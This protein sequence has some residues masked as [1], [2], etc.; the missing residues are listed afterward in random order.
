MELITA[1]E[2]EYYRFKEMVH[3]AGGFGNCYFNADSFRSLVLL[4]KLYKLNMESGICYLID[5]GIKWE[6]NICALEKVKL[7]IP[8]LD[9]AIVANFVFRSCETQTTFTEN[10]LLFNKMKLNNILLDYMVGKPT[11][12]KE[13]EY[14]AIMAKLE[15]SG[16]KF[17][18]LD[19]R[20]FSEAYQI[21]CK[22]INPFDMLG[23]EEMNFPQML[24]CGD[25]FGAIDHK[26]ELC[27]VCIL[28]SSFRGGLTAVV[29]EMRGMGLGKAIKYYSYHVAKDVSKQHLW[30]S[31][32]N[33]K[34]QGLM[35]QMGAVNTGRI[36]RQYV[37]EGSE[38]L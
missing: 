13:D 15:E 23:Y 19:S 32:D 4:K 3:G 10:V 35:Q 16:Y 31:K 7:D 14:K 20:L 33:I 24:L 36:L 18:L 8:R 28:P 29:P 38:I 25:V 12:E 34:N 11:S 1:W 37:L 27:A 5:R 30:I 9:K 21:L 17:G 22:C 6:M 26:G 2:K